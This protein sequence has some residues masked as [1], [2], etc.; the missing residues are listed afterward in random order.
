[1]RDESRV[2][3][4]FEVFDFVELDAVFG[5]EFFFDFSDFIEK[6]LF[7]DFPYFDRQT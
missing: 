6:S 7:R 2:V 5:F 3:V 1:M 4:G